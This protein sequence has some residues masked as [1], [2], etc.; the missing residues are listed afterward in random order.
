MI[1]LHE[2]LQSILIL[3]QALEKVPEGEYFDAYCAN[4]KTLTRGEAYVLVESPRGKLGCYLVS[5]GTDALR[6]DVEAILL[7]LRRIGLV[8]SRAP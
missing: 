8:E 4:V 5:E 6:A 2:T 7:E 3:R 1:R